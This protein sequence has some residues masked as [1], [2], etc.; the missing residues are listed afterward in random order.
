M[1]QAVSAFLRRL[2]PR[3]KIGVALIMGP[4]LWGL[5]PSLVI[6]SAVLLGIGVHGLNASHPLADRQV[7]TLALFVLFWI[8]LKAVFDALAG[9]PLHLLIPSALILGIRLC[10][11]MLLGLVLAGS[12]S[13]RALG[14]AI[15]WALQPVVGRE[16][17]WKIA[18]AL[19]LMVHFLPL[20]LDTM[21]RIKQSVKLRHPGSKFKQRLV[22]V[23]QAVLRALG[24]KTWNQ[25][26]AVAGRRLD[27]AEAWSPQ[28]E[29]AVRDTVAGVVFLTC[30]SVFVLV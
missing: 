27:N 30:A 10:A 15:T 20:C 26:L 11:L 8:A 3:L 1:R 12:T 13:A 2:D 21:E 4:A 29:W 23:P 5:S 22:M 7:R 25:T 28:F 17:A 16:R 24:Q 14:M 18:L 6:A 19:A 9:I